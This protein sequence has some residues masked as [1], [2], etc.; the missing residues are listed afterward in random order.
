[1]S[2]DRIELTTIEP[3]G[4]GR[5][6]FPLTVGLPFAPSVLP[7]G[8]PV[9]VR[10]EDDHAM[11]VQTR[12]MET[13]AD[14]SARWLLLDYQA[15]LPPLSAGTH[16]LVINDRG[17]EVP[18]E[19]VIRT[20]DRDSTLIIESGALKIEID[21]DCCLPLAKV[22]HAGK[23]VSKGGLDFTI[24][25]PRGGTFHTSREK[26]TTFRIEEEGELRF[27]AA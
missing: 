16:T 10:D 27:V 2:V 25:D 21:R 24:T 3:G 4:P 19:F 14:G 12:V 7:Q 13:H 22:W 18:P 11:P 6:R 17:P 8:T 20:S 26:A 5:T 23:L 15:D 9:A 1:M